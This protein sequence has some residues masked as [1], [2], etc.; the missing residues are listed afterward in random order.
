MKKKFLG[1]GETTGNLI[2]LSAL[3]E[4]LVRVPAPTW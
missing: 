2:V 1:A 3:E 4:D